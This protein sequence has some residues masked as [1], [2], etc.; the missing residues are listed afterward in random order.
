MALHETTPVPEPACA[1]LNYL[2]RMAVCE[3][4]LEEKALLGGAENIVA[5]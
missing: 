1:R 2:T 4:S 5:I 3:V